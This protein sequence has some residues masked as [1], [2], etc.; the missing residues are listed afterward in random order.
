MMFHL[1]RFMFGVIWRN[2]QVVL[3]Q[4]YHWTYSYLSD[5]LLDNVDALNTAPPQ[6]N[7]L[8]KAPINS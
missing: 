6:V 1:T 2:L 3:I 4:N 7:W 5:A 8:D